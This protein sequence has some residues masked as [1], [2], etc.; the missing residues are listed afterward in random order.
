MKRNQFIAQILSNIGVIGIG[1]GLWEK[2]NIETL[3][4]GII[5]CIMAVIMNE[6]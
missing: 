5:L 1:L 3:I 4:M 6:G 2:A